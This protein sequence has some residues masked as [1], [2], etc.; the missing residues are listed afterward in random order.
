MVVIIIIVVVI[1]ACRPVVNTGAAIM[2]TSK[3][4]EYLQL[5]GRQVNCIWYLPD[6]HKN[7]ND[8]T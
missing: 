1:G 2:V 4:Y 5:I 6:H 3:V 8:L 7:R